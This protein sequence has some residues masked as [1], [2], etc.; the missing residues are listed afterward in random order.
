MANTPFLKTKIVPPQRPTNL[1]HRPRLVEFIHEHIGR[2]LILISAAAGYGK[3]SLLIDFAYDTDLPVCWYSLDESDRD[4]RV[5]LEG[6]AASIAHRFPQILEDKMASRF[7]DSSA[8]FDSNAV[9]ATLINE[10]H[11]RIPEVFVLLL[12]DF[13]CV[14]ESSDANRLLD[15]FLANL[16]Q[17]CTVVLSSRTMPHLSLVTLTARQEVAG[18][19]TGDLRFSAGEIEQLLSEVYN[20]PIPSEEA[21]RL[22]VESEGWITAIVLTTHGLWKGLLQGMIQAKGRGE[23]VYNYLAEQVFNQQGPEVQSFLKSSSI[24]ET[25]DPALCDQ[26]LVRRDSVRMLDLLEKRN[27]FV[28]RSEGEPVV[29]RYHHLF[30]QFLLSQF[31]SHESEAVR[32]L[33]ER[34][35]HLLEEREEWDAAVGQYLAA[36]AYKDVVRIVEAQGSSMI[37]RA[38]LDTLAAWMDGLPEEVWQEHPIVPLLRG[39]IHVEKQELSEAERLLELAYCS[40]RAGGDWPSLARTAIAQATVRRFQGR[41]LQAIEKSQEVLN[42]QSRAD[43]EPHMA[44]QAYRILGICQAHMDSLNLARKELETSLETYETLGDS[45]NVAN[46]SQDLG[47]VMRRMGR[48]QEADLYYERAL[49]NFEALGNSGR[50]ADVLNDIAVGYYYRGE[51]QKALEVFQEGL[52]KAQQVMRRSAQAVILSGMGDIYR[53]LGEAERALELYLEAFKV[54]RNIDDG[55]LTIYLMAVM[56]DVFAQVGESDKAEEILASGADLAE[57]Q[58]SK[59]GLGL[60]RLSQGIAANREG[61]PSL[62]VDSLESACQLLE[63]VG[64]RREMTRAQFH[65]CYALHSMG[66]SE[67]AKSALGRTLRL[68]AET[69]YDQFFLAE[70]RDM[71]PFLRQNLPQYLSTKAVNEL[72]RGIEE[73]PPVAILQALAISEPEQRLPEIEIKGLGRPEVILD[74][75]PIRWAEWGGP[76]VREFFFFILEQGPVTRGEVGLAFWPDYSPGKVS[77]AFHSTMYRLRRVIPPEFIIYDV[78]TDVYLVDPGWGYWYDVHS[79]EEILERAAIAEPEAAESLYR[80]AIELWAGDYLAEFSSE[81]CVAERE[82]LR[83]LYVNALR[84]LARLCQKGENYREAVIFYHR[85]LQEDPFA[86]G[87][88][89][90][91][92]LCYSAAGERHLA[93]KHYLTYADTLLQEMG[94][95][96][97]DETVELYERILQGVLGDPRKH[98]DWG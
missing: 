18:L 31:Q 33:R 61:D 19:G 69:G 62:S 21:K 40:F 71:L 51:Y 55:F 94:I 29:Y 59:Y 45:F 77:S 72:A 6:L 4:T 63:E 11:E 50:M 56:G 87:I 78:D 10:I 67:E 49:S 42:L 35:G 79:F 23:Y 86:E 60:I 32:A 36:E 44:A 68:S 13:H 58:G 39:S 41:Y 26:L 89:R 22:V 2:K 16:P 84:Q 37:H 38:R 47:T 74:G 97:M 98:P 46:L 30:R 90:A 8:G 83:R 24:L 7:A 27:L 93:I 91:L 3:T 70:G 48:P 75:R 66:R 76:L 88:H 20:L 5:L 9:L 14:D 82:G 52:A 28:T 12:D 43:V 73:F 15:A 96:P 92:M 34:A 1:L 80:Q 81:W 65:L 57:Q 25:M 64:A 17:N 53:D 95:S 85:A 54:A